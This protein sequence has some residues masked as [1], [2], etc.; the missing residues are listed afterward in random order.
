MMQKLTVPMFACSLDLL[1]SESLLLED[2]SEVSGVTLESERS[3]DTG[4]SSSA[5]RT[6]LL[7][8]VHR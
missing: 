5:A 2:K 3:E 6:N 8:Y 7:I 1:S 4:G